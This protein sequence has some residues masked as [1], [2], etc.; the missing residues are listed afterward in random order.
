MS[1]ETPETTLM[2]QAEIIKILVKYTIDNLTDEQRRKLT[3]AFT[4]HVE[5]SYYKG[6]AL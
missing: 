3:H 2:T 1:Q 4:S 5:S 6:P